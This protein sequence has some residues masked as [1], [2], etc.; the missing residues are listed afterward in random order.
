MTIEELRRELGT[1]ISSLTSLGF[2]NTES[3]T[4]EKIDK[5]TFATGELGMK[6]AKRLLENLSG[7]I[8]AIQEGKSQAESGTVR[9]TALDFYLKN[10]PDCENIE[11]LETYDI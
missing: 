3:I 4:M 7:A 5:L 6:E 1:I 9:L 2:N 11:D 8:K 10:L